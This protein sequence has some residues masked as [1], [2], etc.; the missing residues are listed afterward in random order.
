MFH[1]DECVKCSDDTNGY[2]YCYLC[3]IRY[4]EL[5]KNKDNLSVTG[6]KELREFNISFAKNINAYKAYQNR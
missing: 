2:M 4:A 5:R 1:E 6:L 3:N